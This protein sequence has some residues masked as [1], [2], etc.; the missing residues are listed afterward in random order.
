MLPGLGASTALAVAERQGAALQAR[1][2]ARRDNAADADRLREAA[3]R[4]TDVEALLKDRRALTMVLEAFQLES[5][6]NKTAMIRKVLTEDPTDEGSLANRMA[7]PR[8]R[9]LANAFAA[10]QAVAMTSD[11]FASQST[12]QLRGLALN[13]MAGLNFAQLR[14]LS[15]EQI[16]A[17]DPAQIAAV[18]PDTLG[19]M[20][21]EDV[22]A[23]TA[24]QVGALTPSQLRGFTPAQIW[25][26]EPADLATLGEAQLR[27]LTPAQIE[28]MSNPQASALRPEQLQA[29]SASQAAAFT[30]PMRNAVGATGRAIL[31]AAPARPAEAL[32]EQPRA[33]LA[34]TTLVD[35]IVS[36]AMVNRYEKSMGEANAGMREALYFRRMAGSVTSIAGLM[37]DRALTE[38]VRGAL[39]LPPQFALLS[40][41]QQR[42]TLTQRLDL[43]ELQ[44]PKAVARMAQRYVAQLPASQPADNITALFANAGGAEAIAT[45]AG[46]GFSFSA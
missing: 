15:P 31:D 45:L 25:A 46:K 44:D 21:L 16:A 29:F 5:E 34:D 22:T 17:L 1:F 9:E 33:P 20:E 36:R 28:M 19:W 4:I 10:T 18:S 43:S 37:A 41:E 13:Q 3:G 6:I 7:D 27:A 40:F 30:A 42:D 24:D 35:R 12:E 32:V 39:G 23:L 38:V 26:I 11:D 2:A 14:A 8:W